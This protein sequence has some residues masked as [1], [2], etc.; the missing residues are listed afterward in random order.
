MIHQKWETVKGFVWH[1]I[2][3]SLGILAICLA[4]VIY[5]CW[6]SRSDGTEAGNAA[7]LGATFGVT[8]G[9]QGGGIAP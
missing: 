8:F 6:H 7:A 1:P 3:L 4:L 9:S 5:G 2:T